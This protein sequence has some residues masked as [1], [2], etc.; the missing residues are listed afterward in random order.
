[1]SGIP[2]VL[3]ATPT[4]DGKNY[5]VEAFIHNVRSFTYPKSRL[6]FV[7]FDNSLSPENAEFLS[8]KYGVNVQWKDY[9]GTTVIERLALTH[10][11][12]RQ[13]AINNAYDYVLHLE[14][15]I[16]PDEDVI[17]QLLW[18]KKKIIGVPYNL[19][20]GGQR[21]VVTQGYVAPDISMPY[22]FIG[23]QNISFVHHWFFDG[24][25]K[26]CTT[27]GLGCTLMHVKTISR[28]PFRY[29]EGDDSAPD[30]WFTRDLLV[31]NIPYYV[32]TG[33]LAH[34]WNTDDWGEYANLLKHDKTA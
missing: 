23:S 29:V 13:Y 31:N 33:L 26:R 24:T 12:I 17:E 16:F 22:Y 34:H 21:R 28:I 8:K 7:I 19:F 25:V 5:C 4:F 15:D 30:T 20:G 11:A 1:M 3:I 14:S 32:H 18:T 2:K 10:E 6:D 27:N 9:T